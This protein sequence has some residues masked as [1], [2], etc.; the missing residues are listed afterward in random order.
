M[1]VYLHVHG[2]EEDVNR[3]KETILSQFQDLDGICLLFLSRLDDI[4]VAFYDENGGLDRSK[5]FCVKSRGQ[6]NTSLETIS[7][8]EKESS[9]SQLYHV[10]KHKAVV[11]AFP[12]TS[13]LTPYILEGSICNILPFQKSKYS[14]HIHTDF[15]L[16]EARQDILYPSSAN[17]ANDLLRGSVEDAFIQAI[18]NF[19]DHP[20]LCY[21]WPTFLPQLPS[22]SNPFWSKFETSIYEWINRNPILRSRNLKQF[23]LPQHVAKLA[24]DARDSDGNPLLDDPKTDP[25]LSGQYTGQAVARLTQYGVPIL[26]LHPFIDLL[27][28]DL[29][30]DKSRMRNKTTN[31]KWH[32][33]VASLLSKGMKMECYA[34]RLRPLPL[35]PLTDGTWTSVASGP[36]VLPFAFSTA[37]P[38]T[39]DLRVVSSP[40]SHNLKRYELFKKLGATD[41]HV[42]DVEKLILTRFQT[43]ESLQLAEVKSFL[44]YFY[45]THATSEDGSKGQREGLK[46]LTTDLKLKDPHRDSVYLPGTDH[47]CAPERLLAP[48]GKVRVPSFSV[49][50]P[51]ILTD[52][53]GDTTEVR[54]GWK[55]WLCNFC[56]VHECI[57]YLSSE[58]E[59]LSDHFLHV[60]N[61][62]P[63]RFLDMLNYICLQEPGKL[64][65]HPKL[66]SKIK[67]LP[68]D[69]FCK[70]EI[71]L[72][73]QDTWL[74]ISR[75]RNFVSLY[76]E[77]PDMFPFLAVEG[78]DLHLFFGGKYLA[79][80]N[81]FSIGKSEDVD[82]FLAIL[83]Y[84][85]RTCP[86]PISVNQTIQLVD[87]YLEIF[88]RSP[89]FFGRGKFAAKIRAF[90]KSFGVLVPHATRPTWASLAS[91]VWNGPSDMMTAHSLKSLYAN[92]TPLPDNRVKIEQ[93]L[94][95]LLHIK[96]AT[97]GHLVSELKYLSNVK[98]ED[99]DRALG[100]YRYL[101]DELEITPEARNRFQELPLIFAKNQS[102]V[103]WFRISD[104]V[105]STAVKIRSKPNLAESYG[106]LKDLFVDKLGVESSLLQITYDELKQSPQ[107]SVKE[108]KEMIEL[109]NNDL[110]TAA[111]PLDPEP[112]RKAKIFPV[113]YF[114]GTVTLESLDADF[115]IQDEFR[116]SHKFQGRLNLLDIG[117]KEARQW[118]PLFGWL[119][120]QDRYSSRRIQESTSI[121]NDVGSPISS[122]TRYFKRRYYH[123]LRI[124]AAFGSPRLI[125]DP[126]F[127][128]KQLRNIEIVEVESLAAVYTV[129]QNGHTLEQHAKTSHQHLVANDEKIIIYVPKEPNAKE[130]CFSSALPRR[131]AAWLMEDPKTRTQHEVDFEMVNALT[132]I[133]GSVLCVTDDIFYD[134]G[135]PRLELKHPDGTEEGQE[136]WSDMGNDDSDSD[137]SKAEE[138]GSDRGFETADDHLEGDTDSEES[139]EG[140]ST[141]P[142]TEPPAVGGSGE[143]EVPGLEAELALRQ[144]DMPNKADPED[145]KNSSEQ[146][147]NVDKL[148]EDGIPMPQGHGNEEK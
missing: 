2:D 40:A 110:T 111:S 69:R 15:K 122:T 49:L 118:K 37:I 44:H 136:T 141:P 73:L 79:M 20:N 51:E 94:H 41:I 36:A 145:G 81:Y 93:L 1:T 6:G 121:T 142:C 87:L 21:H 5:R 138:Q 9:Q 92:M 63:E 104:C 13:Q 107:C 67:N 96:D 56:G 123:I 71:P 50:H 137:E 35:L 31:D 119:R 22:L 90:F 108:I 17:D 98:C 57:S 128:R 72:T 23:R 14:F 47:P 99:T 8:S 64:R 125:P 45:L 62:L 68:A 3:L 54:L 74:P 11:L 129:T 43:S 148:G 130:I 32:S 83:K 120:I 88:G 55:R 42:H 70:S 61:H 65:E 12:L 52:A 58:N 38:Q 146:V 105:W 139:P 126:F 27:A 66:V 48:C 84:I 59:D 18:Q 133:L 135:I 147:Q 75:L 34:C 131:L 114:D 10:V 112:F 30:S 80:T 60:F 134:L 140:S 76:M 86:G 132:S 117:F 91:C 144:I 7:Y 116:C 77:L 33:A 113:R 100:V 102:S 89:T 124:A 46:V 39:L 115:I 97:V 26:H 4:K 29:K 127:L 143:S 19:C 25:F 106:K 103:G 82:L 95:G 16:D 28:L 78:G 24:N 109:F 101:N 53:P 85:G